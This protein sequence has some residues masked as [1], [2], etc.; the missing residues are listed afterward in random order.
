[1]PNATDRHIT[2]FLS[3][4]ELTSWWIIEFRPSK[5]S[6]IRIE[7]PKILIL[8][9]LSILSL[10]LRFQPNFLPFSQKP[11]ALFIGQ[12]PRSTAPQLALQVGR[13]G[14]QNRFCKYGFA[15]RKWTEIGR[16]LLWMQVATYCQ[17]SVFGQDLPDFR[18]FCLFDDLIWLF[19]YLIFFCFVL[20]A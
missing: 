6:D 2:K 20:F 4:R 17:K 19:A 9:S 16:D 3:Q 18:R 7:T 10:F 13:V 8:L 1:M 15:E 12:N 14:L 5:H 11:K